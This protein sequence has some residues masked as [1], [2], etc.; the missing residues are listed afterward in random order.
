ME[1]KVD[2]VMIAEATSDNQTVSFEYSGKIGV[3]TASFP[4]GGNVVFETFKEI[5]S[6]DGFMTSA[7]KA[8]LDNL[9]DDAYSK[10]ENDAKIDLLSLKAEKSGETI[11][12][13]DACEW[14]QTA[15]VSIASKNLIPI[16]GSLTTKTH[17]GVTYTVGT[18]GSITVNGTVGNTVN[19]S[20][21]TVA[22]SFPLIT[23][24][25][26]TLSGCPQN[27]LDGKVRLKLGNPSGG[28]TI[29]GSLDT[30]SGVSF[31][32]TTELAKGYGC[33]IEIRDTGTTVENIVFKPQLELGTSATEYTPHISDISA[34]SVK[35][36]GRNLIK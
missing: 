36:Y 3:M 30:G 11:R 33:I 28:T 12:I 24:K 23:G 10:S 27:S 31:K 21:F 22:Q 35:K 34:V 20:Y 8:K 16:S 19:Y 15:D 29:D 6:R 5:T 1:L 4:G 14:E 26:Y 13:S 9:P 17:N 18:D 32:L 2:G 7:D 25:Y